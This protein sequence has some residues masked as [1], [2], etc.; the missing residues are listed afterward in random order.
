MSASVPDLLTAVLG[1]GAATPIGPLVS[2]AVRAVLVYVAGLVVVRLGKNRLL[3][4]ATAFDIIL[5]FILGSLFSRAVNGSAS[6][7]PTLAAALVLVGLHGALAALARRSERLDDLVKGRRLVLVR[8]GRIEGHNLRRA[9]LSERDLREE[10]RLEAG[11]GTLDEVAE[12]SM[13]RNG[14]LSVVERPRAP[15]VVSVAVADGV[16][17]VRLEL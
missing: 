10:L 3:G 6:L 1:T 13:E 17:T 5:A 12:V 9:D 14:R 15:R 7:V 11:I 8:D 4:R 16:Q 2:V